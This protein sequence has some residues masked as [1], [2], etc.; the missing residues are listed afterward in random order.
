MAA[1][2]TSFKKGDPRINRGGRPRTFDAARAYSE[3]LDETVKEYEQAVK[4]AG[5]GKKAEELA[6][7]KGWIWY[8]DQQTQDAGG[9]RN[10]KG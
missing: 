2:Q 4:H 8:P 7:E 3:R 9:K 10:G 1:N 6:R 5:G